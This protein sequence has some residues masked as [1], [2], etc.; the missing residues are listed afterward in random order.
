MKLDHWHGDNCREELYGV[1]Y[2]SMHLGEGL[3]KILN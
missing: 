1:D 2:I 3:E